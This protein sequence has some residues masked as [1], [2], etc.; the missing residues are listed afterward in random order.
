MADNKV[1]LTPQKWFLQKMHFNPIK[2]P[3]FHPGLQLDCGV[4]QG[5]PWALWCIHVFKCIFVTDV[6]QVNSKRKAKHWIWNI[7]CIFV[8]SFSNFWLFCEYFEFTKV[9]F[10]RKFYCG[11]R[12]SCMK[13]T[14]KIVLHVFPLMLLIK[15]W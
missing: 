14:L 1:I 3:L 10:S 4:L 5:F 15:N 13:W 11:L 8:Y 6:R 9:Q 7:N 12:K 2:A